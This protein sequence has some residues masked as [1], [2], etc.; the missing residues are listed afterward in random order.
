MNPHVIERIPIA[1]IRIVNPRSRN[2]KTFQ[3]IVK[4][5]AA[6]GLKKPIL[7]FRRTVDEDGTQYDLV[8]GQGRLE[9]C[10][11]L[12]ATEISAIITDAS[13]Q[14]RYLMSLVANIARKR[15]PLTDLL[16]QVRELRKRGYKN[17][18]IQEKLGLGHTHIEGILRLLRSGEVGLVE[19][20]EAGTIPLAIAVKF[21][22]AGGDEV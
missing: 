2:R 11:S 13:E 5:I 15:P 8:C 22:T 14:N 6:V 21:A 12:G 9:A 19:Q 1:Q 10:T 7:V 18:E 16:A 4:N 20:V 17:K 3:G